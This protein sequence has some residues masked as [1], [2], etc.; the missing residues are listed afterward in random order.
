MPMLA[1]PLPEDVVSELQKIP[2]LAPDD[3]LKAFNILRRDHF[4]CRIFARFP[5]EHKKHYLLK[6]I[7]EQIT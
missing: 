1:S 7:G 4:K 6:E 5:I 3:F 2:D